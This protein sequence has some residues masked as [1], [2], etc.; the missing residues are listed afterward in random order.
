MTRF[1]CPS[2]HTLLQVPSDK[3][4]Q[5]TLCPKCGQRVQIRPLPG[6]PGAEPL[7]GTRSDA[8]P[9]RQASRL[10]IFLSYGRD[11]HAGLARQ[12][13]EDL[14][15]RGHTVWFDELLRPGE[16]WEQRIEQGLQQT[17][18]HLDRGRF[19]LLM[20]PHAVRRPDGYCLNELASALRRGLHV[21]PVLVEDCEPP[22]SICRLQ[23]LD[24]R[25]CVPWPD[26]RDRYPARLRQLLVAL[27]ENRLDCGGP[28]ARLLRCLR[29]LEVAPDFDQARH[30]TGQQWVAERLDAWLGDPHGPRAFWVT[31]A[32]GVG[33]TALAAWLCANRPDVAAFHV[34]RHDDPATTD[35]QRVVCSLAYQLASQLPTVAASL[36]TVS[37]EQVAAGTNPREIFDALLV[38]PL[39]KGAAVTARLSLV[40]IDALH[41]AKRDGRNELAE[42]LGSEWTRTPPW[43]LLVLT[44][45]PE[46]EVSFPLQPLS[47][48]VLDAVSDVD[49]SCPKCQTRLSA[50]AN[51]VGARF[52]C[53]RCGERLEVPPPS[54]KTV[55]GEVTASGTENVKPAVPSASSG[56][57]EPPPAP[58][59]STT[60]TAVRYVPISECPHCG[61]ALSLPSD[62]VGYGIE[63]PDCHQTFTAV[64]VLE[65]VTPSRRR[66]RYGGRSGGCPYCGSRARPNCRS[67]VSQSGWI[68]FVVL[69]I[70]FCP[71][72]WIGLLQK[73]NVYSCADCGARLD[74]SY[75]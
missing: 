15:R 14:R 36:A 63:C 17:A 72:C 29:P 47:P 58:A 25:D 55:L 16:D 73:E 27:E 21:L 18:T 32:P 28:Q 61:C 10:A 24:L 7:R 54:S 20:T 39:S 62:Q 9:P 33:K 38:R 8:S 4:G 69:L 41:E 75:R 50:P 22:L 34:C 60:R 59:G 66:R 1:T 67:D 74:H 46:R 51:K 53:P 37:L 45:Q 12:L 71:L 6:A 56:R 31:S 26:R 57:F 2:C 70:V 30:F 42:L 35:P 11:H 68:M 52:P 19:V 49:F 48:R 43:L 65:E 23:Y 40:V 64:A 3:L 44:G 13:A 5:V